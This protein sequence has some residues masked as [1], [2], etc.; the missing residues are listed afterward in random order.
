MCAMYQ[1]TDYGT[2]VFNGAKAQL[3]AM[4]MK[5]AEVTTH[6]PTDQITAQLT[7]LRAAN[8][9][10]IAMGTIVRDTVI[11]Y[12]AAR[13]MGWDVDD[14]N[15]RELRFGRFRRSGG[16]IEVTIRLASSDAPYP[17]AHG[18]GGSRVDR[19]IQEPLQHRPDDLG[20][21][22][23]RSSSTWTVKAIENAGPDL[24]TQK[25]VEDGEDPQLPGHLR[26]P[27]ARLLRN[28]ACFVARVLRS[29]GSKR[30]VGSD[31]RQ[32][33]CC[34]VKEA[35]RRR[36][37][38]EFAVTDESGFAAGLAAARNV[39]GSSQSR[40]RG[41]GSMKEMALRRRSA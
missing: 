18:R 36:L 26:R 21:R 6:K 24:T 33:G 35:A 20:W 38:E 25:L 31:L 41:T 5:F 8:C 27:A 23:A 22:S 40:R 19:P 16:T 11:P 30:D 29:I 4:G 28:G 2:E 15:V 10:L 7:K 32:R 1:D 37:D 34:E 12:S 14:W 13:K 9:D 3:D 39:T 17:K